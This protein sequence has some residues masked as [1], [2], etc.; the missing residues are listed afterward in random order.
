ML[1]F[2]RVGVA[3]ALLWSTIGFGSVP[4]AAGEV[5]AEKAAAR[6]YNVALAF[7][8]KKLYEPAAARWAKYLEAYPKDERRAS[9]HLN[10]GVCQF[11]GNQFPEAAATFREILQKYP[12]FPQRDHAQFNLG[13]AQYNI[14]LGVDEAAVKSQKPA[15]K[16]KAVAEFKKAAAEFALLPKQY[17]KSDRAADALYYQ[18]ECLYLS[19]DKTA[20]APIYQQVV[21]K[22]AASPVAADARYGLGVVQA[23]LMQHAAAA[24]TFQQF[25][26]AHPKDERADECRLRHAAALYALEKYPEAEKLFAQAAA[27]ESFPFADFAL[28][29]QAQALQSQDKLKEAAA[30]YESLPKKFKDSTYVGAALLAGGKCRFRADQFSQAQTDFQAAVAH[31]GSAAA[32]AAWLL[33]RTQIQLKKP[34]E[35]VKT[36]EAAVA[37]YPQSEFLPELTL[38]RIDALYEQPTLRPQT[39]KL[40]AEFAAKNADH[41]RAGEA[42]YRATFIAWETGDFPTA[43]RRAETFLENPAFAGHELKPEVLFL[44][45]ES[46][47][48]GENV[49]K[50]AAEALY[51]RLIAEHPQSDKLP[52]AQVRVGYCLYSARK[53]DEAVAFLKQAA[54]GLKDTDLQAEAWLIVGRAH[55]EAGRTKESIPAFRAALKADP[56]W[57]RG[58]EALLLLAS[59]LRLDNNNAAATVELNKLLSQYPKSGLLDRCYYQLAEIEL[60]AMKHD[61]AVAHYRQVVSSF[62]KSVTAPPSQY[63]VGLAFIHKADWATAAAELSKLLTAYPT[64]EIAGEGRYLRGRCYYNLKDYP[65]AVA[66]LTQY[67]TAKPKSPDA[68]AARHLLGKCQA[69][70][71]QYGEA[72]A[73][74]TAVLKEAPDY[75]QAEALRYDLAF[76]CLDGE[77]DEQAAAAFL[78]LVNKHPDSPLAG[79][80]WYRIGELREKSEQPAE[81]AEAFASGLD[82]AR[83][84]ELREKLHHKLGWVNYRRENYAA[85]AAAFEAQVKEFPE[86]ELHWAAR[87]M[88]G[89]SLYKQAKFDEA[90]PL[91][92]AVVASKA[93]EYHANALYRSGD[94]AAALKNWKASQAA[95]TTLVSAFPKFTNINEARYGLGLALQMQNQLDA[96]KKVYGEVVEATTSPTAAKS[97]YMMGECAFAQKNYKEGY[98]RFLEAAAGYPD[99]GD[100]RQWL[101]KSH[102]EAARCFIQLKKTE[103]ARQELNIVIEKYAEFPEAGNAKKLLANLN[104]G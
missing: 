52:N 38:T 95:Y 51:R 45:A 75:K 1:R 28:L 29:R 72:A 37:A 79:E 101:S 42:L 9:A 80:A 68:P 103:L 20:A 43:R 39:G 18:A 74:L 17:A 48:L 94:C 30:L 82:A 54:T 62:P 21:A 15:D 87:Y 31:K 81:A 24:A 14:A 36:L 57:E 104:D 86:G 44:G 91:Y 59:S 26:A 65:K 83:K 55:S 50:A 16:Q 22:H 100:Y 7:Q 71:K 84:P 64:A 40:Y 2:V 73:T 35:A 53:Y 49:D 47:L 88:A 11:G 32:E 69:A 76:A 8:K 5:D 4:A 3:S 58:D 23:E 93:P 60:S 89:E 96:A 27:V 67:L 90:L 99:K 70:Q 25:V 61:A 97:K 56:K 33:G 19:D 41:A 85:A 10:L 34:A 46:R 6:D 92:E 12:Q 98:E 78:D 102:F 13:M 66:D 63:G 77:K